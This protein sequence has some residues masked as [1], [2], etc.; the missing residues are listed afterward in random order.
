MRT[1]SD[2]RRLMIK[3]TGGKKCFG[4]GKEGNTASY[5]PEGNKKDGK[6]RKNDDNKFR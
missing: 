3:S 2:T 6:K 1:K 4:C 5:C